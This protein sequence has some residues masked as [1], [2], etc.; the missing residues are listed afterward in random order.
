MDAVE[1]DPVSARLGAAVGRRGAVD[2]LDRLRPDLAWRAG[3]ALGPE[4]TVRLSETIRFAKAFGTG[5]A[6]RLAETLGPGGALGLAETF[7]PG[8]A[9]G[10]LEALGARSP[11]GLAA[12]P[13]LEPGFWPVCGPRFAPGLSPRSPS[14]PPREV[15]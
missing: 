11:A 13:P 7:G 14:L 10:F 6:F 8:R 3:G 12:N 9:V 5:G 1:P 4:R 2:A 15:P